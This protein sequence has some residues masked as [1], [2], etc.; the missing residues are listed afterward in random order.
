MRFGDL[1][2]VVTG[3]ASG[4]GAAVAES[5]VQAGGKVAV[6]DRASAR[7][8][9]FV[10]LLGKRAIFI[11]A[12]ISHHDSVFSALHHT[13]DMLGPL[14]LCVNA[15]GVASA[16]RTLD[17]DCSPFP[18]DRFRSIVEVNFT[19]TFDVC[20]LA[21]SLM[22]RNHP[23]D[24]GERGV[25][26]N[27]SSI[28]GLDGPSGQIAYT[29]SKAALAGLTLPMARELA[30]F[31]IRVVTICPGVFDTGMLAGASPERRKD[32]AT[33]QAFPRRF[34][35]PDKFPRLVEAI[36]EIPML[37]GEVIRLDGASR[38]SSA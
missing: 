38:L 33:A 22:A 17:P 18:L 9:D 2:A 30:P 26:I 11:S 10:R 15:A 6:I 29:A 25:I 21:A 32:L 13:V 24:D 14:H 20:R 12:D 35:H 16:G 34:G 37:N 36:V 31:G 8:E 3:G 5:V 4:L 28:A 23:S 27:V 7:G 1:V 19:G